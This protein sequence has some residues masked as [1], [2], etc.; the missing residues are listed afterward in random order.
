MLTP[1]LLLCHTPSMLKDPVRID[2]VS[3]VKLMVYFLIAAMLVWITLFLIT[4]SLWNL[5][6]NLMFRFG[7]PTFQISE[8]YQALDMP[9][10]FLYVSFSVVIFLLAVW[11][12]ATSRSNDSQFALER[13]YAIN[14]VG[15]VVQALAF[16]NF[17]S[18]SGM[19][20][21]FVFAL[22]AIQAGLFLLSVQWEKKK[23][24]VPLLSKQAK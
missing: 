24:V 8:N 15:L 3:S 4:T 18:T 7:L 21:W 9:L 20:K 10:Q 22:I 11:S 16:I 14:F 1:S 23:H 17:F 5:N 6:T 12:V 19:A 13:K 2:P